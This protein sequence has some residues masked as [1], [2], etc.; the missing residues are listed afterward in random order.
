M[1]AECLSECHEKSVAAGRPLA[2]KVFI[3]GR[4]RLEN[5]GATALAKAFKVFML[6][7]GS[8]RVLPELGQIDPKRDKSGTY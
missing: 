1:L 5:D 8:L 7:Q 6:D 4:G 3:S 2:L